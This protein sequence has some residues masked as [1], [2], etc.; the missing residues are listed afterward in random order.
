MAKVRSV[1][2]NPL[3]F[4]DYHNPVLFLFIFWAGLAMLISY[5]AQYAL[6]GGAVSLLAFGLWALFR[7]IAAKEDKQGNIE[8][9]DFDIVFL[10]ALIPLAI[11]PFFFVIYYFFG[12]L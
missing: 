4:R 7:Q 9:E 12:A 8:E 11:I 5:S 3:P 1:Q 10:V 6:V 2:K